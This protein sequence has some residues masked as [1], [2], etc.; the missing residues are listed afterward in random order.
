MLPLLVSGRIDAVRSRMA[1]MGVDAMV[2]TDTTDI[3][4]LTG[5][6]G[7]VGTLVI[8]DV[9]VALIV[10]G[11][12]AEQARSQL[13]ASDGIAEIRENRT[14][15]SGFEEMNGRLVSARRI[16]VNLDRMGARMFEQLRKDHG[17]S[18]VDAT[19][20]VE[21]LRCVKD[22]AE[23]E[24]IERA[25]EIADEALEATMPLLGRVSSECITERD[26]R[27]ELEHTMRRFGAD[28]PSYETIVASG[29]NA[30]LPHH[31]PSNRRIVE[32]D[33]VVIDVGALVDGYHS[34]MTRTFLIGDVDPELTRM[35]RAVEIVQ[36][37]GLEAVRPGVTGAEVDAVCREA[38]GVDAEMFVHGTGHGVGL[39]I[40]ESPWLRATSTQPLEPSEV[41]TVEP[42]LYRV[43]VGGVRIED[44]VVVEPTGCRILTHSPKEPLCPR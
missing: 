27:D 30:A 6:R 10:D 26:V 42:G 3:R 7:S 37:L 32:G 18:V 41:V 34:D 2:V 16:G 40:H 29:A 5:F 22:A 20:L 11:R 12:Y 38:F 19:G 39:D 21:G 28:G 4:W 14:M 43:G 25:C 31:R 8:G 24:R 13:A 1:E 15:L 35:Y 36:R 17:D 9:D 44:L 23:M 33:A